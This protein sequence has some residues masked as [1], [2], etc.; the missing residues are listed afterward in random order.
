MPSILM[1]LRQA[2]GAVSTLREVLEAGLNRG[3]P[4]R[5]TQTF[6]SYTKGRCMLKDH[7]SRPHPLCANFVRFATLFGFF[8]QLLPQC[9]NMSPRG[10][11]G[12]GMCILFEICEKGRFRNVWVGGGG[13]GVTFFRSELPI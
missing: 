2:S 8:L 1:S 11:G 3:L 4:V 6:T 7:I 5:P 9:A 12:G 10:G 13:G